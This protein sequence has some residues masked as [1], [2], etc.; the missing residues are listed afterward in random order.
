MTTTNKKKPSGPAVVDASK[1]A[2]KLATM[3]LEVLAGS[4]TTSEAAERLG[5]S[6]P[7]YYNLEL[8]AINSLISA[9]EPRPKGRVKSEQSVIDELREENARLK[10]ECARNQALLRTAQRTVGISRPKKAE[11]K[12]KNGRRRRRNNKPRGLK[13]IG[14]LKKQE[15]AEP[16]AAN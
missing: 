3:I 11:G 6:M 14:M 5:I 9:C 16:V 7:R 2:R 13:V 8:R 1:E 15:A 12:G 4:A 10:K